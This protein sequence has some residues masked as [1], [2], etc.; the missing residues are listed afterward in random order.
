MLEQIC[1]ATFGVESKV[2]ALQTKI[3]TKD[4]IAQHWISI[5]IAKACT[6]QADHLQKTH[7]SISTELLEWLVMQ[8]SQP[9]N[10]LLDVECKWVLALRNLLELQFDT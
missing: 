5:L 6:Q 9:Y 10:P 3:E 4:K 7:A 8:M 1:L 2:D